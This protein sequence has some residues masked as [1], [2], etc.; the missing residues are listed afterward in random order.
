MKKTSEERGDYNDDD[1]PRSLRIGSV[2]TFQ[3]TTV[4]SWGPIPRRGSKCLLFATASKPA[5]GPT[6]SPIQWVE[7]VM[8]SGGE[9]DHSPQSSSEVKNAWI[10][11]STT[12]HVLIAW[13]F[14]KCRMCFH[15]VVLS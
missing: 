5:L 1:S 2:T 8:R 14:V 10:Y 7:E 3:E 13:C 15:G 4:S 11:T 12:S 9:V 6:H